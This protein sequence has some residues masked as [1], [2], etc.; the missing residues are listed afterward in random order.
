[1]G[2]IEHLGDGPIAVDTAPFIYFIEQ[3]PEHLPRIKPLF[4]AAAEGRMRLVTSSLT[5]LEVL[6]RPLR[7]G[8]RPLASRYEA[9]LTRGDGLE[10]VH[11]DLDVIRT[12]A[13]LRARYSVSTPDAV[14]LAAALTRGCTAFVT[15]DRRLPAVPGLKVIQLGHVSS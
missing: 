11:A 1:V 2:L 9:L 13:H 8:N 7:A 14:H 4:T 12:A 5:L 3:H 10:L 6:V 15:N